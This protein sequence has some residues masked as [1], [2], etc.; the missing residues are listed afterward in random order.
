MAVEMQEY[1]SESREVSD[2]IDR[3]VTEFYKK[4]LEYSLASKILRPKCQI[5]F[6]KLAASGNF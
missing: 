3:I 2:A 5:W 4:G 6:L 1:F